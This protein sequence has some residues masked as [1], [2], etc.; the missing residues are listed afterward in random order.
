MLAVQYQSPLHCGN[1]PRPPT[2][3][4]LAASPWCQ[5]YDMQSKDMEYWGAS[6]S[7]LARQPSDVPNKTDI[8]NMF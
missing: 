2:G 3:V 8:S 6:L 1:L 4:W 5:I 7:G